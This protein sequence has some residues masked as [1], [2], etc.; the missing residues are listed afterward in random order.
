MLK[1]LIV[2][3]SGVVRRIIENLLKNL[4]ISL[5]GTASNGKDALCLFQQFKPDI[6]T[7]DITMPEMD[8]LTCLE[9]MKKIHPKSHIIVVSALKDRETALRAIRLGAY[10]FITKPFIGEELRAEIYSLIEKIQAQPDLV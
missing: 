2:D 9:E 5:V 4:Q 7:L 8:G 6:V 3:D 1:M 10:S